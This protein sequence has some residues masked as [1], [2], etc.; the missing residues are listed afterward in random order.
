MLIVLP[1]SHQLSQNAITNLLSL[2]VN[3]WPTDPLHRLL[4]HIVVDQRLICGH[5]W[6]GKTGHVPIF[7]T[8]SFI[9][10]SF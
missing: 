4:F 6:P 2:A 1:F 3:H 8:T 10:V 9:V 5:K 7:L